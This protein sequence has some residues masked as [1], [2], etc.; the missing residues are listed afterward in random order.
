MLQHPELIQR[1]IGE[2]CLEK[3]PFSNFLLGY[4][5]DF[6]THSSPLLLGLGI[7]LTINPD[8]PGRFGYEDSTVDYFISAVSF[9]WSLR[10]FKLIATHSINHAICS[11]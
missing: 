2:V 10:H 8:D 9:N 1:C 3:S 6:R 11:E 5:R 7:P 4:I